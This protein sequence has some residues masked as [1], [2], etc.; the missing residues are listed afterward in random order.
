MFPFSSPSPAMHTG[1]LGVGN[2]AEKIRF[3][4]TNWLGDLCVLKR[5]GCCNHAIL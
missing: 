2:P 3:L 4:E 5:K 1:D